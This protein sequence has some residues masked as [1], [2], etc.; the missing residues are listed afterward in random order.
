MFVI[1][2]AL[3]MYIYSVF[4]HRKI[5]SNIISV[6]IRR[7]LF[8]RAQAKLVSYRR[9]ITETRFLEK[10]SRCSVCILVPV[11]KV[12]ENSIYFDSN[13]FLKSALRVCI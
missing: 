1:N 12:N 13:T 11:F 2:N 10:I 5:I 4:L 6:I 9:L 3:Y 7:E 8:P